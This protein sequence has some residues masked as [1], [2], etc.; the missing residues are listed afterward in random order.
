MKKYLSN[1]KITLIIRVYTHA[2][3]LLLLRDTDYIERDINLALT[4]FAT[5]FSMEVPCTTFTALHSF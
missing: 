1:S 3:L 4:Q 5:Y 2:S